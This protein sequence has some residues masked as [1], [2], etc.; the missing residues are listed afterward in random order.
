LISTEAEATELNSTLS[1]VVVDALKEQDLF[2][3]LAPVDVGGGNA[4]L[5]DAM[6]VIEE[7]TF[8]DGSSGWSFMANMGITTLASVYLGEPAIDTMFRSGGRAIAAGMLGPVGQAR[9]VEGGYVVSGRFSFGSG[10]AHA[11]W[12]GAGMVVMDGSEPVLRDDQPEVRVV[13]MPRENVQVVRDW[14]VSGLIGTG[15]FDYVV[16]EQFVPTDFT[17][18]RFTLKALRGDRRFDLGLMSAGSGWHAAIALGLMKRALAEIAQIASTKR[19]G[20]YPGPLA[21]NDLFKMEFGVADA[22]YMGVR[23]YVLR[24]FAEADH[25]A[26]VGEEV[27]PEIRARLRQA[28]TWAHLAGAEIVQFAHIWGGSESIRWD[29]LLGRASRDMAVATQHAFVDPMTIMDGAPALIERWRAIRS[30]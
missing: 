7:L 23:G 13:Y 18:D 20:G 8:A 15:S 16:P 29:S 2:W 1:P 24:V 30:V 21:E 25:I 9:L 6:E 27:T 26:S 10:I 12:V 28:T 17:F 11:N 22:K 4:P 5:C 3:L 14:R 19:R